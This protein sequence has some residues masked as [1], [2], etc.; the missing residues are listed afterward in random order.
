MYGARRASV[1]TAV[2][3]STGLLRVIGPGWRLVA[4]P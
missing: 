2:Y 3:G 4:D 1:V